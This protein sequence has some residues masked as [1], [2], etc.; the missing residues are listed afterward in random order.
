MTVYDRIIWCVGFLTLTSGIGI[1]IC[2]G[3]VYVRIGGRGRSR[4]KKEPT[5]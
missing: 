2:G 3:K 5:L 1:L 4:K